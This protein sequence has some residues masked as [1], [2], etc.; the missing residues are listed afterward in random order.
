MRKPVRTKRAVRL[1][2]GAG[3]RAQGTRHNR[4]FN[5][6]HADRSFSAGRRL[7]KASLNASSKDAEVQ[8][9]RPRPRKPP[10]R[11][12]SAVFTAAFFAFHGRSSALFPALPLRERPFSFL[13]SEILFF[14]CAFGTC[15]PQENA[16]SVQAAAA[17]A[18]PPG[19]AFTR[20]GKRKTP[21]TVSTRPCP[22]VP[23]NARHA[24]SG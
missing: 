1:E 5:L 14:T 8:K 21:L 23:W 12:F 19:E 18:H 16:S 13:P 6:P 22:A 17:R 7:R 3:P 11:S 4:Q 10:S 9:I 15:A 2:D 20:G 24:P